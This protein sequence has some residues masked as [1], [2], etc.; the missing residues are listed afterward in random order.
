[1]ILTPE[2][3]PEKNTQRAETTC[4]CGRV[5]KYQVQSCEFFVGPRKIVINNV[6]QYYCSYCNKFI[7]D[8]TLPVDELLKYAFKNNISDIDW[9]DKEIYF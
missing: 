5:A 4:S 6:P 2:L 9:N 7:F 3:T 8:S 1:M